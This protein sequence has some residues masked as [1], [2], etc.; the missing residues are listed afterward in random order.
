LTLCF[1][2]WKIIQP[3]LEALIEEERARK[4][5]VARKD[6]LTVRAGEFKPF[7]ETLV[8]EIT[9]A[10][11]NII[12]P[13]FTDAQ[14]LPAVAELLA[15]GDA[16]EIVT[17]ERFLARKDAILAAIPGYQIQIKRELVKI[18][19]PFTIPTQDQSSKEEPDF[20]ILNRAS[21]LFRC[22]GVWT[23]KVLLPYPDIFFHEH[24]RNVLGTFVS[25]H[26]LVRLRPNTKIWPMAIQLLK[27]LGLA[28]DAPASA[29]TDLKGRF[30]CHCGHP[31]YQKPMDFG[32][33]VSL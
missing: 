32:A 6:R 4:L 8:L 25:Y 22:P 2:V 18:C 21:T 24:V 12:I 11:E 15:E 27:T 23:C 28:E 29:L 9:D 13:T 1:L 26:T 19:P 7:W 3:K 16:H 30:I 5:E 33:L 20:S 14:A 31:D 17:E 10:Q